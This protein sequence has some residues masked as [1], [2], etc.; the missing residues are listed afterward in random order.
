MIKRKKMGKGNGQNSFLFYN[1]CF[2]F[3]QSVATDGAACSYFDTNDLLNLPSDL[4]KLPNQCKNAK[5]ITFK[6]ANIPS[7]RLVKF[8]ILRVIFTSSNKFC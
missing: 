4:R 5:D 1:E 8:G 7:E 2:I 6:L 3:S